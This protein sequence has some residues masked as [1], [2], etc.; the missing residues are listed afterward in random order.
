V[1]LIVSVILV[2]RVV[3]VTINPGK[4]RN[5]TKEERHLGIFSICVII[6]LSNW[7]KLLVGIG[8]NKFMGL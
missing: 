3:Q 1:G 8:V 6:P 2:E 5:M 4:L 7:I